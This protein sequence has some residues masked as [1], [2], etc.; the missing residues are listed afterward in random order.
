MSND[1]LMDI[2]GQP[3]IESI[4]RR[5]RLRWFGHVNRAVD[6]DGRPPL[7][8]NTMFVYFHGENRLRN[9]GR[10]KQCEEQVLKDI[11][12]LNI[13]N[14]RRTTLDRRRWREIIN[15]NA[16]VKPVNK[17]I[18]NIIYDYKQRVVQRRKTK[19]NAAIQRR[20]TEI[21]VKENNLYECSG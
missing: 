4:I 17:N 10:S 18:K 14:W 2:T 3:T 6:D 21:L 8:K 12:A 19:S 11:E 7:T 20:V 9:M 1:I 5:D 13:V 15:K 16:Y